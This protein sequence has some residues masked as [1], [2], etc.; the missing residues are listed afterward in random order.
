MR[1]IGSALAA[2]VLPILALTWSTPARADAASDFAALRRG[3]MPG[4]FTFLGFGPDG[5]GYVRT[6]TCGETGTTYCL[7]QLVSVGPT[8]TIHATTLLDVHA[9]YCGPG[10]GPDQCDP[11]LAER[12]SFVR[13][14]RRALAALPTLTNA[15][16]IADP[17]QACGTLADG[18]TTLR[19]RGGPRDASQ[20]G[21]VLQIVRSSGVARTLMTLG[22]SETATGRVAAAFVAPDGASVVL[23]LMMSS[24][25]GEW[26]EVT[27]QVVRIDLAHARAIADAP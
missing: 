5:T 14:E 22:R 18:P 15:A 23:V 25:S 20:H 13:R 2:L 24:T 1:S 27:Q 26:S 7:A 21:I 16:P 3:E 6:I 17:T 12:A 8:G 4:G 10:Y 11:L 9:F 19:V